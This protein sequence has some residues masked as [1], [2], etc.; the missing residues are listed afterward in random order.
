[1]AKAII[2]AASKTIFRVIIIIHEFFFKKKQEE[3]AY[4][5]LR[6]TSF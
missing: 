2:R 4:K 5:R 6:Q 3:E 1:M